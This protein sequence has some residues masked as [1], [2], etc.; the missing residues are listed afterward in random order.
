MRHTSARNLLVAAAFL[1]G[2]AY[3]APVGAADP[4]DDEFKSL[5]EQDAK[6]MVGAADAVDKAASPKEKKVVAKNAGSGIKSSAL[7]VAT[8]A[9]T[10]IAG[11]DKTADAKAAGVRDEALKIYKAAADGNFKEAAELAKGLASAKPAAEGKKI[12]FLKDLGEV[13]QKE[14]MHNF[15]KTPQYGTNVEADIK[16]NGKK[17]TAKPAETALMVHRVLAMGDLNKVVVKAEG[18]ADKKKWED[19]N[20]KMIAATES[21]L[22]ATKKKTSAADLQKAFTLVDSTCTACHDDF[23]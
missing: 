16:A 15:L 14:V 18:A 22:T 19:Y 21:L 20:A 23:K 9:N 4:T 3:L 12:E 17:A 13:T 10:R 6:V 1:A 7:L 5:V 2:L 11:K 8:Y